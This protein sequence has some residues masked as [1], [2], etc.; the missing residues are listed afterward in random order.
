MRCSEVRAIVTGAAQGIGRCLAIE[1]ARAGAVVAAGDVQGDALGDLPTA[2][3]G[4]SGRIVPLALDVANEA[5]VRTFLTRATEEIGTP[6]L[7][8]NNAG[9]LRDGLLVGRDA[10]G[11]V[12]K[13]PT[14]QWR[15]VLDTN[16][17]GAFLMA[18]ECA[19]AMLVAGE[20]SGLIVNVSSLTASGNPGQSNYAAAKAGLDADTRTWALELAPYGI[21]VVGIAPGLIETAMLGMLGPERR[22]ELERQIPLG[23]VGSP[24]DIWEGLRFAIACEYLTGRVIAIDGG[25]TFA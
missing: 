16:L 23:R 1:L 8:V 7:L 18:R 17:T 22:D 9:I 11:L 14:A 3:A 4:F 13:L 5:S 15:A 25:A 21:R 10:D 19:A 2:A 6:N 20:R 12:R 24:E